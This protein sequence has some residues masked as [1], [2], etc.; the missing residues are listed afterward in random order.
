[1]SGKSSSAAFNCLARPRKPSNEDQTL[2][3][4]KHSWSWREVAGHLAFLIVFIGAWEFACAH[5]WLDAT[6]FG[7][8]SEITAYLYQ[9]FVSKPTLW[10]DLGYTLLGTAVSFVLGSVL[11]ILLGLMFVT[12]PRFERAADPYLTLLNAMPRIALVPLFLLWFGL[13]IG[14]KIAVGTSLSFFIVLANTVAGIR[15]VSGDLLTLTRSLGA[16]PLQLFMQ[17]T[18]PSAVPVIASGL[19]LALV[20][21]MLGVVGAELIAAEHGLGQQLAYMQST[22]NMNGVMGLLLV[23][24]LLGVVV[25]SGM[26]WLERRLLRWQ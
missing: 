2:N 14:S 8:P 4:I 16:S 17:V 26:S 10:L 5:G 24:A 23:L 20:Y 11:A 15:G 21:S 12:W 18:L 6:F 25:T 1:M 9:G 3:D 13:G 22:F 7:R 19:R